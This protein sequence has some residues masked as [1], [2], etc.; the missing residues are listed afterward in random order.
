[1]KL[2]FIGDAA[3]VH[4]QRWVRW[5]ARRHDV[6]VISTR[7]DDGLEELTVATLPTDTAPGMRLLASARMVRRVAAE[8]EPDVVHSHFI[9]EAGWY[10]ALSGR[11]PFVMTAWGSDVYR[12]VSESRLAGRLNPWATRRADWVTCDSE[13][14]AKVI[15]S[16]GV[17]ADR[18]SVIGWGVDRSE[19]HPGVDGSALR[20]TLHIPGDAP[21]VLSPRQWLANSNIPAIVEAHARMR[22]GVYLILKRIPSWEPDGGAGIEQVVDASPARDRIRV[23]EE[24]PAS[25]LPSLYAAADAVVSLCTTDGTP[26]SVLEAMALGRPV[27]ALENASLAEWVSEPGGRLV[28]SLDPD[29]LARSLESVVLEQEAR[30]Q[31]AAHNVSVIAERAD[32]DAELGRM[33]GI[34]E[35]LVA[36]RRGH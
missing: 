14:Q 30:E 21:V 8:H 7:E 6:I 22:D 17:A 25:E 3:S 18:I 33:E 20:A 10:G 23:V 4:T 28:P 34:Y 31:A 13:D 2:C 29:V 32:R 24:M 5:F 1:M 9:N 16:W 19:F 36:E 12:A 15:R 27:V 11:R 35:R 26:V